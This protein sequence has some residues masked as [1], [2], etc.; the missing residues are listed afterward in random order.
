GL[1]LYLT[2]LKLLM[3]HSIGGRPLLLLAILLLILGVQLV[4]M[5]LLGEM[6]ARVYH[7]TQGKPIYM[8]KRTIYGRQAGGID[9]EADQ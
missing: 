9:A 7:E 6:V 1:L 8:V 4:G 3:G 2:S 5:G